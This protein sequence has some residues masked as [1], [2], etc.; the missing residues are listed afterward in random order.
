MADDPKGFVSL[1]S[2]KQGESDPKAAL[3]E[4]RTLYFK[5]TKQTIDN[6]LIQ[7]IALFK[8]LPEEDQE[9]GVV[10]ME[11]LGEMRREWQKKL[12]SKNSKLKK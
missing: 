10:Y 2:L 3:A 1:T 4:L 5:T 7:A 12:K 9:K 6:D 8:R 11:G